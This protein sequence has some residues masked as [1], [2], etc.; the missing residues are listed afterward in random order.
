MAPKNFFDQLSDRLAA[1]H[2]WMT[3]MLKQF[4][5]AH[6]PAHINVFLMILT[7][8]NIQSSSKYRYKKWKIKKK[9]FIIKYIFTATLLGTVVQSL[10]N[11]NS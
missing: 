10:V 6:P 4:R 11:T 9:D 3:E 1:L 2:L 5:R 7:Y 8:I